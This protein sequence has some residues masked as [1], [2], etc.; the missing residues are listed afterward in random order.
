MHIGLHWIQKHLN[1]DHRKENLNNSNN[2]KNPAIKDDK[3]IYKLDG[4]WLY[5]HHIC[6]YILLWNCCFTFVDKMW[7]TTFHA[8]LSTESKWKFWCLS[9]ASGPC[10]SCWVLMVRKNFIGILEN[11]CEQCSL[12]MYIYDSGSLLLKFMSV[13]LHTLL[14]FSK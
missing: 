4:N 9:P 2:N 13:F 11:S 5:T 3:F 8:F 6:I 12:L 14:L 7:F 1:V 10:N